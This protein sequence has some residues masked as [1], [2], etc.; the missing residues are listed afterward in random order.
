MDA[1]FVILRIT[2][3]AGKHIIYFCVL[4]EIYTKER[5]QPNSTILFFPSSVATS[6][7]ETRARRF[8]R[9][10]CAGGGLELRQKEG[11]NFLLS[12]TVY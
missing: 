4:M 2:N 5:E 7:L 9:R 1:C 6:A 11:Y 3:S 8:R 12:S 10:W